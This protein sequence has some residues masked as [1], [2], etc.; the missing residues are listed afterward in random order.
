MI[1]NSV[2]DHILGHNDKLPTLPGIAL[3]ILEAVQDVRPPTEAEPV[4]EVEPEAASEVIETPLFQSFSEDELLGGLYVD[5]S[6]DAGYFSEENI[7]ALQTQRIDAYIATGT[8]PDAAQDGAIE[9]VL[10]FTPVFD[11]SEYV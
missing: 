7:K 1:D 9:L 2:L 3:K 4:P 11:S 6:A 10:E 5:L 8:A